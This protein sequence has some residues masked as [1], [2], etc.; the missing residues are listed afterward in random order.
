VTWFFFFIIGESLV[1]LPNSFHE[2]TLWQ[3]PW[4]DQE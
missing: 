4:T 1:R 2:G 3:V